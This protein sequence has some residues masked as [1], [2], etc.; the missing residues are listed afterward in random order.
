MKLKQKT[1]LG[2]LALATLLAFPRGTTW[3]TGGTTGTTDVT[4]TLPKILI[5]HYFSSLTLSF[6]ATDRI[7]EEGGA[8]PGSVTLGATASPDANLTTTNDSWNGNNVS[9]TVQNCWAVRGFGTAAVYASSGSSTLSLAGTSSS[10]GMSDFSASQDDAT[11]GA[12]TFADPLEIDLKGIGWSKAKI[13]DVS[14]TLDLSSAE[15]DGNYI[16][17]SYTITAEAV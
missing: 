1:I 17:G 3:A 16:G 13:G 11:S 8:T 4:V 12:G 14:F 2:V 5:L 7:F 15:D 6:D 10:I 9:L